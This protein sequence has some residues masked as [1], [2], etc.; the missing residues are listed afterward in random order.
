MVIEGNAHDFPYDS[1]HYSKVFTETDYIIKFTE[2]E[3]FMEKNGWIRV[4]TEGMD[5]YYLTPLGKVI[6][7][8]DYDGEAIIHAVDR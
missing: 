2:L 8:S 1:L 7:V 4:K 6:L 5:S 3:K